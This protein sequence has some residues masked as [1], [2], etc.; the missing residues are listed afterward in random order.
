[1]KKTKTIR[2][3][4]KRFKKTANNIF[5]HKCA[6]VRHI[7]TKKSSKKKRHLRKKIL[8]SKNDLKSIKKC[9]PYL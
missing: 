3:A 7:L 5:K 1:M 4:A 6:N 2:S 8:I 9:L